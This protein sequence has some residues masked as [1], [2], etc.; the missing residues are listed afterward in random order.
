MSIRK[1]NMS[2]IDD[3]VDL[4][5]V[6]HGE[7]PEYRDIP[8]QAYDMNMFLRESLENPKKAVLVYEKDNVIVGMV[9]CIFVP[10]MFN[11]QSGY[12]VDMGVYV[13]PKHRGRGIIRSLVLAYVEWAESL[14]P[15]EIRLGES[16]GIASEIYGQILNKMGFRECG[17]M[18]KKE[19]S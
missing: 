13:S 15:S 11:F 8:F 18:Y 9:G 3:L 19:K 17:K 4:S 6:M 7:A 12:T 1:A 16:A 14:S 2:D 10:Y 5:E